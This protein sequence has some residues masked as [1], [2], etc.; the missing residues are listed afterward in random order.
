MLRQ[1]MVVRWVHDVSESS[2]KTDRAATDGT[3]WLMK[4][5]LIRWFVGMQ[6]V[7]TTLTGCAPT[8]PFFFGERGDLAHYIDRAQQIEYPDLHTEQIPEVSQAYPPLSLDNQNFE[9]TDLTLEQCI[10]LALV[11]AQILRTLPGVQRQ[12]ADMAGIILSSPGNQLGSVHDA[13]LV[14][15]TTSPQQIAIDGNGNRVPARGLTRANQVGGVEDALSEFDAQYSSFISFSTTDRARNVGSGNVFNPQFFQ[16]RDGTGQMA[17]SK[18]MA[19]GGVATLRSQS[20]Y[21]FNNIPTQ[22]QG[23]GNFGRAVPSDYTQI[24]EAGVQHPLL[25]GRGTLVNR[26]P[27]VVARIN[28]DVSLVEYEERVRNLVR[29]VEFAYWD[30]YA[31]Y[32]NFELAKVAREGAALAHKVAK[33]RYDGGNARVSEVARAEATYQDLETQVKASL[34][35]SGAGG[36]PGLFGRERNLR[37][38]LGWSA[39]DGRL[40]RPSDKPTVG[41][42]Q[43]DLDSVKAELYT[44]NLELRRQKWIIK[45]KELELISAKNQILPDVNINLLY[46]WVGVGGRLLNSE[47]GNPPFPLGGG[48]ASAWEELFGGNYQ[49][50]VVR[51]E[52]TP[53]PFGARRAL[54]AITNAQLDL[55][56][57][58]QA[59]ESKEDAALFKLYEHLNNFESVYHQMGHQL[60]AMSASDSEVKS[61]EPRLNEDKSEFLLNELLRAQQSRARA[62]QQYN[63][64]VAEYNKLLVDLHAL[65]GSLLEYNNIQLEEGLWADKAYWDAHERARVRDAAK[66]MDYG[67]SRPKVISQGEYQQFTG[68]AQAQARPAT[69]VIQPGTNNNQEGKESPETIPAVPEKE[70]II[71][72]ELRANRATGR[73]R[74]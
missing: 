41:W 65:K 50:G 72:P 67:A 48:Q 57:N 16:G 60:K 1:T 7:S 29:D 40:I 62:G 22:S 18:R 66:Y 23:L 35:G 15:T 54:N 27:I 10:S 31:S 28:E 14:A 69:R 20:I 59:L 11:N 2:S 70:K 30:L 38:L 12:N 33:D 63:R 24:L 49:E 21:S 36:D 46:R 32:W 4:R 61:L 3:T 43:F 39:S 74:S 58:H 73:I 68:T 47:G 55:A 51:A 56:K 44:R 13:A 8:Q 53:N 34:A 37:F 19:T 17:L 71:P 5:N 9:Y 64:L 6:I 52:F 25:R 45:Q 26:I 42:A